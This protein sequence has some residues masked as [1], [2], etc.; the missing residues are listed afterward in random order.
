[1]GVEHDSSNREEG[2]GVPATED[3]DRHEAPG[4]GY[5]GADGVGHFTGPHVLADLYGE[6]VGTASVGLHRTLDGVQISVSVTT[7]DGETGAGALVDLDPEQA[8]RLGEDLIEQA[9]A[10]REEADEDRR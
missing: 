5:E 6:D 3:E 7:P 4:S 8:E 1:M 2:T 10:V 9:D